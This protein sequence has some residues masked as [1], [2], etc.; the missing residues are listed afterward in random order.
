M[1]R[2][3]CMAGSRRMMPSTCI[4]QLMSTRDRATSAPLFEDV[5]GL[6][7]AHCQGRARHLDAERAAEA[8]AVGH[9]GQFA[10][11]DAADLLQQLPR[12][13]DHAQL[14]PRVAADVHRDLV[15]EVGADVDDAHRLD[16][17]LRQLEHASPDLD[18]SLVRVDLAE[19][20][21]AHRRARARRRNDPAMLAEGVTKLPDHA[22][23]F[24]PVARV[25][26]RLPAARLT[27]REDQ[28]YAEPGEQPG[29]RFA[30]LRV[31]LVDVAG[32]EQGDRLAGLI[33]R[34][35]PAGWRSGRR[36]HHWLRARR[37]GV[38]RYGVFAQYGGRRSA[39]TSRQRHR[40]VGEPAL[41]TL[42]L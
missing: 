6:G 1:A 26:R 24:L 20:H 16:Q 21:A 5:L 27:F 2:M 19:E 22:P 32:N 28:R 33:L 41:R 40:R 10:V 3:C 35:I 42:S 37:K 31:E 23:G 34:V 4:R 36:T 9:V 30:D 17:E 13:I 15:R 38:A 7:A 11:G 14:A 18:D 8:A 29:G 25:E 39:R 12:R